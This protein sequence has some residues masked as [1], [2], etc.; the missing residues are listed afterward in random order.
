L[1]ERTDESERQG[2][3]PRGTDGPYDEPVAIA[4]A[5]NALESC[6]WQAVTAAV[7]R[8]AIIG[9]GVCAIVINNGAQTYDLTVRGYATH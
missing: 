5:R 7:V 1:K 4:T 2:S 3:R 9:P 6:D 8:A